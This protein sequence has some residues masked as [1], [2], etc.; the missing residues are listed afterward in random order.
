MAP[1]IELRGILLLGILAGSG[2]ADPLQLSVPGAKG[3]LYGIAQMD[4]SWENHRGSPSPGNLAYWA[5]TGK[6]ANSGEWNI[7]A[8]NTKLGLNL[9][10]PDSGLPVRLAGKVEIDFSGSAGAENTPVPRLRLGYGTATFPSIGLSILAGQNWDLISPLAA[11]TINTGALWSSGNIGYRRPQVRITESIPVA[12][13]GKVEVAGA[14]ARSIGTASP[15]VAAA[16]D[17]GHDADIPVF[18]GRAAISLPL[19]TSNPAT[20]GFS[21]HYGQEDVLMPDSVSVTS[22]DSW[23]AGI[24]LEVPLCGFLSLVGEA[25]RGDNL[26][27]Y[28]GGIGQGFVRVPGQAAVT[29]VE[30]WGGWAAVKFR[31]GRFGANAGVGVDSVRASTINAGGRTRNTNAFANV[32][33]YPVPSLRVGWEIERIETDYKAGACERLWRTQGV[34]ALSF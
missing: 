33:F 22:L 10:G 7:T 25:F 31:M 2:A 23:S 16:S 3:T 15:F 8:S 1:N 34:T 30:G 9:S 27:G 19:W 26:D 6:Y 28:L 12:G 14:V 32:S 5:E 18:Q 21:G 4:M 13:T 20:L 29:N 17:G 24:D 11:P